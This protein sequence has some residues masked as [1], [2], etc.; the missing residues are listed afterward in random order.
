MFV[1]FCYCKNKKKAYEVK[2]DPKEA[3]IYISSQ[4]P[5][6]LTAVYTQRGH[7]PGETHLA[8]V[9]P[10]KSFR[11]FIRHEAVIDRTSILWSEESL[12]SAL[13]DPVYSSIISADKALRWANKPQR[14]N[15]QLTHQNT[16]WQPN[17]QRSRLRFNKNKFALSFQTFHSSATQGSLGLFFLNKHIL[18]LLHNT[19]AFLAEIDLEGRNHRRKQRRLISAS[20]QCGCT[21]PPSKMTQQYVKCVRLKY[22]DVTR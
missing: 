5:N 19:K 14:I 16:T 3:A 13:K 12:S 7:K 2:R 4:Q 21:S 6:R 22:R 11:S 20:L 1:S 10:L 8:L 18:G 9:S 17:I 15:S